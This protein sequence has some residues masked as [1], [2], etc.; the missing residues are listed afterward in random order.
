MYNFSFFVTVITIFLAVPL[1]KAELPDWVDWLLVVFVAAYVFIH[2]VL[3]VS[4]DI[5]LK[6]SFLE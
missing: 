6:F 1:N 3:S 2:L 5:I 4:K